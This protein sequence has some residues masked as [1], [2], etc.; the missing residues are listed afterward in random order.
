M[1][2]ST[3]PYQPAKAGAC[4]RVDG[5]LLQIGDHHVQGIHERR[6]LDRGDQ[7][8]RALA[9]DEIGVCAVDRNPRHPRRSEI[10]PS[11]APHVQ[12]IPGALASRKID[13]RQMPPA[14]GKPDVIFKDLRA[15]RRGARN[16]APQQ[17]V[18]R[19]AAL[20]TGR[21][22]RVG[23]PLLANGRQVENIP[24]GNQSVVISTIDGREA[25]DVGKACHPQLVE[26]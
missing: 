25:R 11:V 12:N 15:R 20:L 9:R 21:S 2:Q 22:E 26:R 16:V 13:R 10:E 17:Q 1:M 14:V 18:G 5:A 19:E 8:A 24:S 23:P 6:C 4:S 3:M 7:L